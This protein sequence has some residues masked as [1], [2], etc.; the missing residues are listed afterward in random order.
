MFWKRT[1][2]RISANYENFV[3]DYIKGEEESEKKQ[4]SKEKYE[5]L[6]IS[7]H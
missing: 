7:T 6:S 3:G 1:R 5:F 4:Y 2:S